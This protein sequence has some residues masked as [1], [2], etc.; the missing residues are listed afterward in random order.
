MTEPSQ[1]VPGTFK[2]GRKRLVYDGGRGLLRDSHF[3]CSPQSLAPTS[4]ATHGCNDTHEGGARYAATTTFCIQA[5][6]RSDVLCEDKKGSQAGLQRLTTAMIGVSQGFTKSIS[7]KGIGY[8]ANIP[9]ET[10]PDMGLRG[11]RVVLP[12][13]SP[14]LE[15]FA[16]CCFASQGA[17]GNAACGTSRTHKIHLDLGFSHSPVYV[18]PKA[19]ASARLIRFT[20]GHSIISISGISKAKV[21]QIAAEMQTYKKPEPYKGKGIRY[22]GEKFFEKKVDRKK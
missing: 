14:N 13:K 3:L 8:A 18:L 22:D 16:A 15:T 21:N 11:H 20:G 6:E 7:L 12:K 1:K 9:T 19:A 4:F 5:L 2:K 17:E 10:L